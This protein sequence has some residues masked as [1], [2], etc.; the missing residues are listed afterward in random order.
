MALSY[1]TFYLAGFL[2][3]LFIRDFWVFNT[4]LAYFQVFYFF[5]FGLSSDTFISLAEFL[6]WLPLCGVLGCIVAI[7]LCNTMDL[8]L[9]FNYRVV[10]MEFYVIK[11]TIE[12]IVLQVLLCLWELLPHSPFPWCGVASSIVYSIAIFISFWALYAESI[13]YHQEDLETWSIRT[14]PLKFH[15]AWAIFFIIP[16]IVMTILLWL[17]PTLWMF[18]PIAGIFLVSIAVLAIYCLCQNK[19]IYRNDSVNVLTAST[20]R[21]KIVVSSL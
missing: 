1:L 8:P 2:W 5:V 21:S 9:L 15:I 12:F 4:V 7:T 16:I 19:H 17:V 20:T 10:H 3:G 13:W 18:T 6:F 11:I 14:T